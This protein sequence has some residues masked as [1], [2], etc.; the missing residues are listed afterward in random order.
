MK[1]CSRLAYALV[2]VVLSYAS[3]ATGQQ[4]PEK[5]TETWDY[6]MIRDV[7]ELAKSIKDPTKKCEYNPQ[8]TVLGHLGWELVQ[9]YDAGGKDVHQISGTITLDKAPSV[10]QQHG[11]LSLQGEAPQRKQIAIFKRRTP[12][13]LDGAAC[14]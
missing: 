6:L 1:A 4:T 11:K 5:S 2:T 12:H 14:N 8:L 7:S 10:G 9:I 13:A 3:A